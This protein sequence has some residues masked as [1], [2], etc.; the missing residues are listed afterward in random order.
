MV[1]RTSVIAGCAGLAT[2]INLDARSNNFLAAY[3]EADQTDGFDANT[4][5]SAEIR[6]TLQGMA[7][8]LMAIHPIEGMASMRDGLRGVRQD[9]HQDCRQSHRQQG[10]A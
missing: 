7:M 9:G 2:S 10:F 1:F 5:I 6:D 8:D 3:E 4:E